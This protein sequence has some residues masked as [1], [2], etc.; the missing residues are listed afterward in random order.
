MEKPRF[1]DSQI[2]EILSFS[3]TSE[4]VT[5]GLERIIKWRGNSGQDTLRQ[6]SKYITQC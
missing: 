6:G 5:C 1:W 4:L 3:L 2:I